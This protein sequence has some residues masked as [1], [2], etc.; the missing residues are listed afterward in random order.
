M[1]FACGGI[2]EMGGGGL[3]DRILKMPT[4]FNKCLTV[5][6]LHYNEAM[7][8]LFLF[9]YCVRI[10]PEEQHVAEQVCRSWLCSFGFWKKKVHLDYGL[11]WLFFSLLNAATLQIWFNV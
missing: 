1:P 9:F 8:L 4:Y 10:S 2:D 11:F 6:Y 7:Q 3:Y 5:L